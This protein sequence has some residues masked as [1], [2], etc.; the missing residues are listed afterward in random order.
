MP[1][2]KGIESASLGLHAAVIPQADLETGLRAAAK[3][4]FTAFE[5]EAV[6]IAGYSSARLHAA[7]ELR[8]EL[9]LRWGPLNELQAFGRAAA[10]GDTNRR[11]LDLAVEL[12][13][14]SLTVIP[15]PG[16]LPLDRAAAELGALCEQAAQRSL[17]LCFEMLCFQDRPFHSVTQA[18]QL[19]EAAGARLVV[20]T[21]HYIVA[22]VTAGQIRGL[23]PERIGVVHISD[24]E[25]H[26]RGLGSL[27]DDDRVLPGEGELQLAEVMGALVSTSY[28]GLM[29]VE[30]FH[31]R[32]TRD[33]PA[34]VARRAWEQTVQLL[35]SCGWSR[36]GQE[37]W[38]GSTIASYRP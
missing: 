37:L 9:G 2:E 15:A 29:S 36:A 26:G 18:L 12:E 13:I 23:L 21:F 8:T 38:G 34:A 1:P 11:L 20:D 17:F 31:P 6:R 32:Y 16:D 25:R 24:A 33:D 30:V 28:R 10:G 19:A 4:G 5:P 22:G 14:P 35:G 27:A 7:N 3:A